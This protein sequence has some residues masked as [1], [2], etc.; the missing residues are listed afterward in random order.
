MSLFSIETGTFFLILTKNTTLVHHLGIK[1]EIDM[2]PL[3]WTMNRVASISESNSKGKKIASRAAVAVGVIPLEVLAIAQNLIKLPFS[4]ALMLFRVPLKAANI[5]ACSKSLRSFENSLPGFYSLTVTAL[6][7]IGYVIGAIFSL[8]IGL[9]S[10]KI[11]FSLHKALRLIVD[12]KAEAE[13]L[14]KELQKAKEQK[15]LTQKIELHLLNLKNANSAKI[16]EKERQLVLEA[17][18]Q[19]EMLEMAR[20]RSKVEVDARPLDPRPDADKINEYK[21]AAAA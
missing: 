3:N 20:A 7:V 17:Q 12:E 9:I 13:R 4:S 5:I 18:K 16:A 1:K 2:S 14:Q 15:I 8:T 19:Q 21:S 11:N 10:P 6:K